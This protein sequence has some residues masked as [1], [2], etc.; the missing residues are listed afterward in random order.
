VPEATIEFVGAFLGRGR[1]ERASITVFC[2][3]FNDLETP[4]DCDESKLPRISILTQLDGD[5]V[6]G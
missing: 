1:N 6:V 5:E 4:V 3:T 2:R